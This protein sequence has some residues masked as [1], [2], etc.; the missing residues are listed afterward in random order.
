M[1]CVILMII[2][3]IVGKCVW[4]ISFAILIIVFTLSGRKHNGKINIIRQAYSER[5]KKEM[6]GNQKIKDYIS[7]E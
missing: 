4:G 1:M 2:A 3:F 6:K 5:K 7:N